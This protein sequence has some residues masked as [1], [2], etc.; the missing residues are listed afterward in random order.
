MTDDNILNVTRRRAL[1]G[2]AL[3]GAIGASAGAGTAA[4]FS[5]DVQTEDNTIQTGDIDLRTNGNDSPTTT[6]NVGPVGP[7]QSGSQSLSL[8][9][10]GSLNGYLSLVFGTPDNRND[11][12]EILEVTVSIGGTEIRRGTFDTVFDGEGEWSNADV[13]LDGGQTKNLTIDWS[14]PGGAGNDVQNLE[15]IGDITIQL[16]QQQEAFADL[17]VGSSG[18]NVSTI[19]EAVDDVPDGGVILVRD[20]T[21]NEGVSI[22]KANLTL[23]S[24]NPLGAQ[25]RTSAP[26]TNRAIEVAGV[27][28]VTV[29][30]FDISFDGNNSPNS[31][32]YAVRAQAVSDGLTVR[33]CDIGRFSTSDNADGAVRATGVVVTS[34]QGPNAG[35]EVND[36]I[37][38]NNVF[39]DIKTTGGTDL[40]DSDNDSKAK[41]VALNG[42]VLN[43][44]VVHNEFTNIGAA[45]GS[46]ESPTSAEPVTDSGVNGT[47][48][49]RGVTLVEDSNGTGPRNFTIL[50]N[51]FQ[52]IVGTWGQPAIFVGGSNTPGNDHEVYDNEFHHPVDNLSGGALKLRNNT[53][54]N[55]DDDD[56]VPELVDPN[57]DNDG[58]NL[59]D[60]N[61]GSSYDTTYTI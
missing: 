23:A 49:P 47:E 50:N 56:G 53:W 13:P 11:L 19:Q 57:A 5:D 15:A 17:V 48:K 7:G 40:S 54:V 59:I 39:D 35:G 21:Y 28:G 51:L 60:R 38:E 31:E 32:K 45:G 16:N 6:I 41:G 36:V 55:D 27:S 61:G 46:N 34:V 9:N 24:K 25:I 44:S 18:A 22:D 20:G 4:Y 29:D 10:V 58:G 30:G 1:A 26:A 52:N 3:V 33:N 37:V 12:T 42:N 14:L 8:N 2:A 43:A